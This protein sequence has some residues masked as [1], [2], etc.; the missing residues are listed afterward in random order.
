M[1]LRSCAYHS[2]LFEHATLQWA[3]W[4]Y[5]Q[6]IYQHLIENEAWTYNAW[7]IFS[8]AY[9]NELNPKQQFHIYPRGSYE[10]RELFSI[11]NRL[12]KLDASFVTFLSVRNFSLTFDHLKALLNIP[13]LA[14]LILEQARPN[15]TSEISTRNFIDFGRAAREKK[16]LRYLRVLILSDFG[17]NQKAV[18]ETLAGFPALQLVGLL[19]T[20][21]RDLVGL[22]QSAHLPWTTVTESE[23]A[24]FGTSYSEFD[25]EVIWKATHLTGA[26]KVQQLYEATMKF[27]AKPSY[28]SN[29]RYR[30]MC[31]MYGGSLMVN[32]YE[33][34]VWLIRHLPTPANAVPIVD[35]PTP[36]TRHREGPAL[37]KRKIRTG[38]QLDVGPLLGAFQ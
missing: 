19:N 10:P 18:C 2:Q 24:K 26:E 23:L 31:I 11:T 28:T 35:P 37:K 15:G 29:E 17:I 36:E 1:A 21:V 33:R 30:S 16:A 27:I 14:T 8:D 32:S 4:H 20:K 5:A 9:P 34:T 7:N 12:S 38:K 3:G 6:K 25:P 22:P 13:T